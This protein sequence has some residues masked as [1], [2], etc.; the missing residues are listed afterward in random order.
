MVNDMNPI[1]EQYKNH[2]LDIRLAEKQCLTCDVL[3]VGSGPSGLCA[4]VQAAELGLKV[5]IIECN[6]VLGGN[7]PNTEGV[8]AI[9]SSFQREQG[10]HIT[11]REIIESECQT[12][13]YHI[14]TLRWKD[15]IQNSADNISWLAAHNVGFSGV[16]D[17]CKGNAKIKPFHWFRRRSSDGRG[18]G[19]LFVD[20]LIESAR[21]SG[22]D[23]F[24]NTRGIQL[25]SA[26][27]IVKGLYAAD[28]NSGQVKHFSCKAVI[29]ATGGFVDN[30][31]MMADRGFDVRFIFR[32]GNPGHNGDG[33]HMAVELGA[34]DV[35][36]RRAYLDKLYIYPL[37]PYSTTNQYINLKGYT[38]WVNQNGERFAN[39]FCGE[40]VPCYYSNAKLTQPMTYAL[41]DSGFIDRFKN[42]APEVE[43]DI[44]SLATAGHGNCFCASNIEQLAKK[45]G[46][47]IRTLCSTVKRYNTLCEAGFDEDFS[48]DKSRLL[49]LSKPPYY[50]VR[51][52]YG[53]WTSIG[54]VRTNRKFEVI[55][56]KG[57]PIPGL[58]CV[59]V[60]GCELYWDCYTI[61]V[62]GSA[63]GNNVNSGRTAARSAKE[64]IGTPS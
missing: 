63:N 49:P 59:G 29:L 14:D 37:S 45:A 1:L 36:R 21:K 22:V 2:E 52:D 26:G 3:V 64:Y 40:H 13:N 20:P 34:E 43:N 54:A 6:D 18:D 31:E 16:V 5:S 24:T 17:D 10:I 11:L 46:I 25:D 41:F 39:E 8:F 33:L 61:T 42:L 56:S 7:G 27:G 9:N 57:A 62:P 23:I 32:R 12:F 58:Y 50:I 30:D 38:L 55:T 60:E 15:I 28:V 47:N 44:T 48:K 19:Y 53:V 4:A 35:S 51:Q